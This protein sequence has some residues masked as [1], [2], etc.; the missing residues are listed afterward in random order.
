MVD[1]VSFG[2]NSATL[3]TV[4][5]D[6]KKTCEIIEFAEN[7]SSLPKN[8]ML[9]MTS[10]SPVMRS[11]W[12]RKICSWVNE[13]KKCCNGGTNANV[14]RHISMSWSSCR[15]RKKKLDFRPPH[16]NRKKHMIG[17]GSS[18]FTDQ[19][20]HFYRLP[21]FLS[22]T[23]LHLQ[24]EWQKEVNS[25]FGRKSGKFQNTISAETTIDLFLSFFQQI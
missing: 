12:H 25:R 18:K 3:V 2:R 16:S 14:M 19:R 23:T 13:V 7:G 20:C 5:I 9:T 1:L 24:L 15:R 21:P 11:F 6:F 4:D 8:F 10:V 17:D 22:C